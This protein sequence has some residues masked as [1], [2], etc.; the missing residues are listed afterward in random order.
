[1]A[2]APPQ[3]SAFA[4]GGVVRRSRDGAN[5]LQCRTDGCS[6]SRL[7]PYK[8]WEH[9]LPRALAIWNAYQKA[10]AATAVRVTVRYINVI[11]IP[12]EAPDLGRYL[13]NP[14]KAPLSRTSTVRGF[15]STVTLFET[16]SNIY[17]SVLQAVL[18]GNINDE[19]PIALNV[20]AYQ[21]N[22]EPS[23]IKTTLGLLRDTKNRLFF[24]SLTPHALRPYK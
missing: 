6:Y 19:V 20:E 4:F 22:V 18:S 12:V 17:A 14:P 5:V 7:A 11:P 10:T 3:S 13:V 21:E 16:D 15:Y 24:G 2:G 1:V 9:A 8:S 23:T